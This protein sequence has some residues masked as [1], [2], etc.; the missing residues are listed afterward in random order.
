[1]TEKLSDERLAELHARQQ[2]RIEYQGGVPEVKD[3]L[4]ALDE[5]IEFRQRDRVLVT[6]ATIAERNKELLERLGGH[7]D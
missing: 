1:M 2:E 5:L 4:K 7:D 6:A 3:L